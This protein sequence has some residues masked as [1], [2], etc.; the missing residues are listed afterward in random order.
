M[1]FHFAYATGAGLIDSGSMTDLH[2]H[3]ITVDYP[4]TF[5]KT[6]LQSKDGNA[7][8]QRGSADT[9][10]RRWVWP[11]M[12]LTTPRY[13]KLFEQLLTLQVSLRERF[14]PPE[15]PWVFLKEDVTGELNKL[16]L[17]GQTWVEQSDYI[18]VKVVS[19]TEKLASKGGNVKY[20]S[21]EIAFYI[22][23]DTWN[24]F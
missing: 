20:A 2:P 8:V 10:I 3:P 15:S 7:I 18:R 21:V 19:V 13:A 5:E 9:R 4:P 16:T 6:S 17:S 11:G 1:G 23:D 12:T 24:R 22:D 14:T